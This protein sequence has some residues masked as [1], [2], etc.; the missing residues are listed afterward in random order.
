MQ[1]AVGAPV[2]GLVAMSAGRTPDTGVIRGD[3]VLNGLEPVRLYLYDL[4]GLAIVDL[5]RVGD[6][7]PPNP[8]AALRVEH[9]LIKQALHDIHG[10]LLASVLALSPHLRRSIR[11]RKTMLLHVGVSYLHLIF[12][13]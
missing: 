13:T 9:Q 4:L 12:S 11:G 5:V 1:R 7:A 6:V 2:A 3:E 10:P 8:Q